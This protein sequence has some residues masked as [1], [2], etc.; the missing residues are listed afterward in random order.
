MHHTTEQRAEYTHTSRAPTSSHHGLVATWY[1]RVSR[2]SGLAKTI[3]QDTVKGGKKTRQTE[4]EEGRRG[5]MEETGCEVM[6][7][8]SR[9][10]DR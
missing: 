1:G 10:R 7:A 8:A 5:K 2:S 6:C 9:L 4:E 3:S